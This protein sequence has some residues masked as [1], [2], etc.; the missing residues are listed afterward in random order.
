MERRKSEIGD[1]DK[2]REVVKG[3]NEAKVKY[4]LKGIE[5]YSMSRNENLL[6]L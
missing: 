3:R 4:H 6:L 5:A 1:R 2:E